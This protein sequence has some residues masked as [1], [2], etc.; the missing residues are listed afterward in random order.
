MRSRPARSER[1]WLEFLPCIVV[2]PSWKATSGRRNPLCDVR[3]A[4]DTCHSLTLS[5]FVFGLSDRIVAEEVQSSRS[6]HGPPNMQNLKIID[7]VDSRS[8]VGRL[9]ALPEP[10]AQQMSNGPLALTDNGR[11]SMM[12]RTALVGILLVLAGA[13]L[14]LYLLRRR[15]RKTLGK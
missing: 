3:K 11:A 8:G 1:S 2:M 5:G 13:A 12:N 4:S 14:G 15:G 9:R 10:Q 6:S 7:F